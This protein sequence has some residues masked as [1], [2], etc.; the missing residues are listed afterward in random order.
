MLAWDHTIKV[1]CFV[2]NYTYNMCMIVLWK[3]GCDCTLSSFKSDPNGFLCDI[4]WKKV[5]LANESNHYWNKLCLQRWLTVSKKYVWLIM[6]WTMHFFIWK[7]NHAWKK[8]DLQTCLFSLGMK[9]QGIYGNRSIIRVL[10]I[11]F[12]TNK[13]AI[14]ST[15]ITLTLLNGENFIQKC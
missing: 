6:S 14:G 8:L 13:H 9:I 15:N 11:I 1:H 5:C 4:T 3:W 12:P 7:L 2:S 10:M